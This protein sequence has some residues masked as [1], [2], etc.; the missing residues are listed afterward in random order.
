VPEIRIATSS[1]H[2]LQ[3]FVKVQ[4]MKPFILMTF[5]LLFAFTTQANLPRDKFLT[6]DGMLT[7]TLTFRDVQGGIAGFTGVVWA[8]QPDGSWDCKRI[9]GRKTRKPDLSG[10]LSAEQLHQMTDVLAHAQVD[11]LPARLGKFRGA[12][13]HVVTL[14][15]GKQQCTWTLR[16]GMP[17]PKYPD[18]PFGKLTDEDRFSEIAQTVAKLLKLPKK[19]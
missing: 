6:K 18:Q 16:P 15:W 17:V 14:S 4:K 19:K 5:F 3:K 9:I 7:A 11:K 8:I 12:N 10:K 1:L 13:P 2:R